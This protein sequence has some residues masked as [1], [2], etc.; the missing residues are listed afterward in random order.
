VKQSNL[1]RR[2]DKILFYGKKNKYWPLSNFYPSRIFIDGKMW[3]TVEHY[4]QAHKSLDPLMIEDIRLTPHPAEAKKKG[5]EF[6]ARE[7]W[8]EVKEKIMYKALYAKFTQNATCKGLLLS[9]GN[10][11]IHEDSPTDIYWGWQN[12][13]KDRLGILLTKIRSEL[14]NENNRN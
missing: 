6:K 14:K 9:T 1:S 2:E 11:S 10:L 13:G 7:D 3:P 4:Y 5:Y 12:N 8:E